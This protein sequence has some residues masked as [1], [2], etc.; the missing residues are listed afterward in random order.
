MALGVTQDVSFV[1]PSGDE[2]G[3]STVILL[4]QLRQK[5]H[6]GIGL[7]YVE[8]SLLSEALAEVLQSGAGAKWTVRSGD[9][10]STLAREFASMTVEGG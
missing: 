9:P 1:L 4:F 10:K 3:L 6:M 7:E 8:S 5:I 2:G